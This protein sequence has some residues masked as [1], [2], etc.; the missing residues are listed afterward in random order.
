LDEVSKLFATYLAF[1]NGH[2][3]TFPTADSI[4]LVAELQAAFAATVRL[5]QYQ[6]CNGGSIFGSQPALILR[7]GDELLA[8]DLI[9]LVRGCIDLAFSLRS[10]ER[11]FDILNEA[12]GHFVRDNFR[13]NVEDAQYMTPPEVVDF[14]VDMVLKDVATED[15]AAHD[16]NKP[17]LS[18]C[19]TRPL[20]VVGRDFAA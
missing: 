17:C 11:P 7:S 4:D 12:F 5:R 20:D 6:H 19:H 10:D 14:M 8:A 9:Q 18:G 16:M 3:P 15:P 1:K 13:S 2:I